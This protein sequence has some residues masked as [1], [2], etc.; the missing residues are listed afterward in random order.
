[1]IVSLN[2]QKEFEKLKQ[3]QLQYL[4]DYLAEAKG[5]SVGFDNMPKI[6]FFSLEK[7]MKFFFEM[8]NIFGS[9][10]KYFLQ[11]S[12][13]LKY[14]LNPEEFLQ[15]IHIKNFF[16]EVRFQNRPQIVE[17]IQ[18]FVLL[19]FVEVH[20]PRLFSFFI[21]LLRPFNV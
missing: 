1:M 9:V 18:T 2:H 7:Y 11:E 14:T 19:K 6:S 13:R 8:K 16:M 10:N 17:K 15:K 5:I 20:L 4:I 12:W 3:K 21:F